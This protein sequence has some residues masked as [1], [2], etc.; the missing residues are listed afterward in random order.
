MTKNLING[1]ETVKLQE[2]FWKLKYI[3]ERYNF[4]T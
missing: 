3:D 4:R 1:G 2:D